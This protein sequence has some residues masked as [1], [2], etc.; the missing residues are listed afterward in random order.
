MQGSTKSSTPAYGFATLVQM[1]SAELEVVN[2][3]R[4]KFD[5]GKARNKFDGG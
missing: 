1:E 4:N 3:S 2:V 5:G